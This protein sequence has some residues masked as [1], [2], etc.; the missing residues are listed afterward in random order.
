MTHR[1]G[2]TFGTQQPQTD[3]RISGCHLPALVGAIRLPSTPS[4]IPGHQF[5]T[6]G[7]QLIYLAFVTALPP[8]PRRLL[9]LYF[10]VSVEPFRLPL[11]L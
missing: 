4:F 6:A 10:V 7:I 2:S 9:H 11:V 8:F 1:R 5:L 3:F